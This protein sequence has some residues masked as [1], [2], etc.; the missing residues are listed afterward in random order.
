MYL[1]VGMQAQIGVLTDLKSRGV[2]DILIAV[3]DNLNDFTDT[4]NTVLPEFTTPI[5]IVH[6]IYYSCKYFVWK[7]MKEFTA[8]M[9][10]IYT[11]VNGD[12]V[13]MALSHFE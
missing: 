12:Q 13:V 11:F 7:D 2:E 1:C 10:D 9:K 5:C 6:Q 8:D 3:T 4:I